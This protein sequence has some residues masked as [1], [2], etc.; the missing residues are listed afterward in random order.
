M[1]MSNE[2]NR[3]LGILIRGNRIKM[4]YSLRELGERANIS[5]TLISN[6]EKGKQVPSNQTLKD[7]FSELD[8]TFYD[9]PK[10]HSE[11]LKKSKLVITH[12]FNYDYE[13][14][15]KLVTELRMN[16]NKYM[17]SIDVVDYVIMKG[18]YYASTAQKSKQ[19]E[20]A[21]EIYE[22]LIEFFT[23]EQKQMVYFVKGMH[24]LNEERY[25]L[26]SDQFKLA[27]SLGRKDIDV[28]IQQYHATALVK[29]YK[30]IDSY[31]ITSSIV[32][33]FEE[34]TIYMRAMKTKLL[35][36]R[37]YYHIAKNDEVYEIANYVERFAHRYNVTELIEE[38]EMFRAAIDIRNG[39]YDKAE[40]HLLKMPDQKSIT[41]VLLRFKISYVTDNFEEMEQYFVELSEFESVR[42]NEKVWKYLQVQAMSR[43]PRFYDRDKYLELI[44]W[45]IDFSTKYNDQEMITLSYNYLIM[46]YHEE[47]SYKKALELAEKLLH[48]KKIRI[49]KRI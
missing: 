5:H 32:K 6:I 17:Y 35:M 30:F 19:I 37:I 1:A 23:E 28:F 44:K 39:H 42:Q 24:L 9:E 21:L 25:N 13:E 11:F 38:C 46:F 18:F 36:A 29:Q 4:G 12:V 8:L 16:E 22:S 47:R 41:T 3:I 10:L 49:D 14:A 48:F 40:E 34:R 31:R 20:K 27:L 43:L 26:A 7:L 45:L 33:E 2:N 15:G